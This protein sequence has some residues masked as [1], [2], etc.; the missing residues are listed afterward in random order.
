LLLIARH[1]EPLPE[2]AGKPVAYARVDVSDHDALRRAVEEAEHQFGVTDCLVNSAGMADARPFEQVEPTAYER[3]I[4]TNLLGVLNGIKAVL[5]GMVGRKRGTI[6]NISSVSDRKTCPVA[7]GYTASKYAV[8]ALT[9]SLR[10]AV[11]ESNLRR[12][13]RCTCPGRHN[14]VSR[15]TGS[16]A[17]PAGEP[18][19]WAPVRHSERSRMTQDPPQASAAATYNAASDCYD[20]PALSFRDRLGQATVVRLALPPGARVLDV[21]CGTG[22]SALTAAAAVGP[23]GSVLGIDLAE[24]PLEH[25]RAKA[26]QRGLAQ[27]EFRTGDLAALGLPAESF[28]AVRCVFGIFFVPDMAAALAGLWRLVRPGGVLALTTWGERT[29]EPGAT[30][31]WDAVREVRPALERRTLPWQRIATP[32]RLSALFAEAQ[33]AGAEIEAAA[34]AHPLAAVEDWW[35][36]VLGSAF[37]AVVEQLASPERYRVRAANLAALRAQHIACIEAHVLYATARKPAEPA[38]PRTG[39]A[40][41]G[42]ASDSAGP[43]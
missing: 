32:A 2:F 36:I 14:G 38:L 4:R 18:G 39:H 9:E 20:A 30:A 19:Q 23:T 8:R 31:F 3:E 11:G 10:E 33:V 43:A 22:A 21:C 13:G 6:I 25:A 35:T 7:V 29:Y 27:A 16:L 1:L 15:S 24:R 37:R 34:D 26:G 17:G 12:S 40:T 42:S 41:Q 5:A 28:D